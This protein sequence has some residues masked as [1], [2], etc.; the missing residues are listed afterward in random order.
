MARVACQDT[1]P[2]PAAPIIHDLQKVI[3]QTY[4]S[5]MYLGLL[6]Y[7]GGLDGP[8]PC[9]YGLTDSIDAEWEVRFDG[10]DMDRCEGRRHSRAYM[11]QVS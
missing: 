2:L 7:N 1:L 4:N 9:F 5:G 8:K 11:C 10:A 3:E 6:S